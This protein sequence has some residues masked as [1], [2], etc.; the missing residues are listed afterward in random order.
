MD[1]SFKLPSGILSSSINIVRISVDVESGALFR[2]EFVLIFWSFENCVAAARAPAIAALRLDDFSMADAFEF[3]KEAA[4][5]LGFKEKGS[6][7]FGN[8]NFTGAGPS[9]GTRPL[10]AASYIC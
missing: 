5:D 8:G 2:M 4:I 10:T 1:P 9:T 3:E 6:L 7:G